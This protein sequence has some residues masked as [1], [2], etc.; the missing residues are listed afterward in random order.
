MERWKIK[1]WLWICWWNSH[2]QHQSILV[3]TLYIWR[4]LKGRNR[5]FSGTPAEVFFSKAFFED[6]HLL[7]PQ[8]APRGDLCRRVW[9]FGQEQ[10]LF[11][12]VYWI[13][14]ELLMIATRNMAGL[15]VLANQDL[16]ETQTLPSLS[17]CRGQLPCVPL[18][19]NQRK[20]SVCCLQ[21]H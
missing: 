18:W 15:W 4:V 20:I 21:F 10:F 12:S 13:V 2:Y 5:D 3:S 14:L 16:S 9:I 6:T 1:W 19:F 17:E 8:Q 11:Y 7:L